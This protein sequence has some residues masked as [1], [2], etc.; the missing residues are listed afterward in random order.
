[1]IEEIKISN[2]K[3]IESLRLPLGRI[4]VLIGENGCG[5]SNI[6]E[7]ITLLA[8]AAQDKLDNEFLASRGIRVVAPSLMR[9]AFETNASIDDILLSAKGQDNNPVDSFEFCLS[10]DNQ[11]YSKWGRRLVLP[12][13]GQE[14][15]QKIIEATKSLSSS[16]A[17]IP[18][19]KL[20][21]N[22]PADSEITEED[23]RQIAK[24][25]EF[26]KDSSDPPKE[27]L[28]IQ[29]TAISKRKFALKDFLIYSPENTALRDQMREGQ[30]E[31]LGINGEGLLRL[32][33]VLH[34]NQKSKL[35]SINETLTKL[36]WF[37]KLEFDSKPQNGL[38]YAR[39]R[40]LAGESDK[41]DLRSVN[42]GFMLLLFYATL[43]VASETP[44]FFAIDNI[45]AS[46]NP[47]L[48][49]ELMRQV[50]RLA[51]ANDKQVILTTHNPAIL[52]GLNLDDEEQKLFVVSRN[53]LGRTRV[54]KIEKP[55][56]RAGETPAR[57]SASFLDGSLGGLPKGF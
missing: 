22:I 48:C 46:L 18:I 24:L 23:I 2:Y 12:K 11:P 51:K 50:T 6:L 43:M 53:K 31:P 13:Q 10:N 39:D 44:K 33:A 21:K 55:R 52:D 17:D 47:K 32:L 14:Q 9:S 37:S 56:L 7:A 29:E 16:L 30:I 40:Y 45:D 26:L 8:A 42:E 5:K 41:L 49:T 34:S 19:E 28:N 15:I 54:R 36:D 4:N 25:V 20:V 1:M 35:A 27:I 3:S 57:L 38:F